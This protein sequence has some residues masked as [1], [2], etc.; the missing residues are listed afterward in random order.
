MPAHFLLTTNG[1][2]LLWRR[3]K[4]PGVT[5]GVGNERFGAPII[6]SWLLDDPITRLPCS[7]DD[8]SRVT[9]VE[10]GIHPKSLALVGRA[11]FLPIPSAS[12]EKDADIARFQ[13]H[14]IVAPG[15]KTKTEEVL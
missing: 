7:I 8:R 15:L 10:M 13:C 14:K 11:R 12:P 5:V 2:C 9:D 4:R 1:G 6:F 3:H